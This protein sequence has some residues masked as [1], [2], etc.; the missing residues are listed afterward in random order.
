MCMC[1]PFWKN[2]VRWFQCVE[3]FSVC[4]C[5]SIFIHTLVVQYN[6]YIYVYIWL[7]IYD[8][9]Y[10]YRKHARRL[11]QSTHRY[12]G[13]A[14]ANHTPISWFM[15]IFAIQPTPLQ[16]LYM[17]TRP[18]IWDDINMFALIYCHYDCNLSRVYYIFI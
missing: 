10:I 8:Y 2:M 11:T 7:Y 15:M 6:T 1:C 5:I 9:I 14:M 3:Y 18:Q 16:G 17:W 12:C 4:T 13:Q